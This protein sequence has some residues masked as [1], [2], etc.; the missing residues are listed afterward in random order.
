MA[1]TQNLLSALGDGSEP[2]QGPA[3]TCREACTCVACPP[4]PALAWGHPGDHSRFPGPRGSRDK[5]QLH[6][7]MSLRPWYPVPTW[8]T[9]AGQCTHFPHTHSRHAHPRG[10]VCT[11]APLPSTLR[12][13]GLRR[14]PWPLRVTAVPCGKEGDPPPCRRAGEGTPRIGRQEPGFP[15]FAPGPHSQRGAVSSLGTA[16]RAPAPPSSRPR[17]WAEALSLP[18]QCPAPGTQAHGGAPRPKPAAGS[19]YARPQKSC[20]QAQCRPPRGNVPSIPA[21]H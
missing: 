20:S 13:G 6:S 15:V 5:G 17:R 16:R 19:S 1:G 4:T 7:H 3:C 9:W 21:A 8:G 12:L 14:A 11:M 10:Q 2:G 18:S